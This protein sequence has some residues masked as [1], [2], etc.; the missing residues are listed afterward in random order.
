MEHKD[1]GQK[2][3]ISYEIHANRDATMQPDSSHL[4]TLYSIS[5]TNHSTIDL[6]KV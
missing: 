1:R 3:G 6:Y 5:S 4:L 2:K